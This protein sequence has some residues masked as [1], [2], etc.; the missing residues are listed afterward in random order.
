MSPEVL[1]TTGSVVVVAA[2]CGVL[3]AYLVAVGSSVEHLAETLADKVG[4][5]AAEVAQHVS[6]IGPAAVGLRNRFTAL[7]H[8]QSH[9]VA[10]ANR[11]G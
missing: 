11:E 9:A 7:E 3:V 5:G 4:P 1:L 8:L 10:P 2:L 6:A